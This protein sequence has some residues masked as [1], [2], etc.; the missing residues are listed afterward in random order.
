MLK[1]QEDRARMRMRMRIIG[2]G[3]EISSLKLRTKGVLFGYS[4]SMGAVG[5][6]YYLES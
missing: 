5:K 2:N 1:V 3:Q 6:V 4:S